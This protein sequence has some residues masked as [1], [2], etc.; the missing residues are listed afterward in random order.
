MKIRAFKDTEEAEAVI[1]LIHFQKKKI[2]AWIFI[3]PPNS[4]HTALLALAVEGMGDEGA[5]LN[6]V[7]PLIQSIMLATGLV[8]QREV[9][10]SVLVS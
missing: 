9:S 4:A 1:T 6:F 8:T 7:G 10:M 2:I 5:G 3:L